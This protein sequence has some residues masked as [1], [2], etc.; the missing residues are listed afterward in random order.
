MSGQERGAF[1]SS[2]TLGLLV[3]QKRS[4]ICRQNF[5]FL[6]QMKLLELVVQNGLTAHPNDG[7]FLERIPILVVQSVGLAVIGTLF[8]NA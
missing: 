4:L 2:S 5:Q 6:L 3:L 1:E 7:L 8:R